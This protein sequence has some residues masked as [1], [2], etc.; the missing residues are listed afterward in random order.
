VVGEVPLA[1]SPSAEAVDPNTGLTYVALPGT[2]N[3][4]VLNGTNAFFVSIAVGQGPDGLAFDPADG[5]LFVANGL[6]D[7]LTVFNASTDGY[8]GTVA[9]GSDPGA[10]AVA[11]TLDQL[12]V[13]DAAGG[14]AGSLTIVGGDSLSVLAT[15]AVGEDPDAAAFDPDNGLVYVANEG[16]GN[17]SV[18]S[19]ASDTVTGSISLGAGSRP[20]AIAVDN[21][22][23]DLLVAVGGPDGTVDVVAPPSSSILASLRVGADPD[24][25][26]YDPLNGYAYVSNGGSGNLSVLDVAERQ[27]A[28]TIPA[29][30]APG[31]IVLDNETANLS[32]A[33]VGSA[34][35]EIVNGTYWLGGSENLSAPTAGS[36]RVSG[37]TGSVDFTVI[38]GNYTF[39]V[40]PPA[41]FDVAPAFA[42]LAVTGTGAVVGVAF[43]PIPYSLLTFYDEGSV[44]YGTSW[45]VVLDGVA[46]ATTSD[47][48]S[49]EEP[50]GTYTYLLLG[51]V[52]KRVDGIPATGS[53]VLNGTGGSGPT[54]AFAFVRGPTYRITFHEVGLPK[55]HAWCVTIGAP[56]CSTRP[57][58]D[59]VGLSPGTYPYVVAS[60]AG[61]NITATSGGV[62]IALAGAFTISD[63]S[64]S[65]ALKYV[66]PYEVTFTESGLPSGAVWSVRIAGELQSTNL[67]TLTFEI[68]NGTHGY[69]VGAIPGYTH[70]GVPRTVKV[71][72]AADEVTIT[73]AP[74]RP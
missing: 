43:T 70:V 74:T 25:L 63:R 29:G 21:A 54:E 65:V 2:D 1:S 37:G 4:T 55:G 71:E 48:E 40:L 20:T 26:C 27:V 22:T 33:N 10:L 39:R 49:F 36:D 62:G 41:G 45:T 61:D 52:G 31:A 16:S 15:L 17:L 47:A 58:L 5:Y 28:G 64:V 12:F 59:L 44:P 53:V 23:G 19:P 66:R 11:P 18:V 24:G 67:T 13:A 56:I 35:V 30:A 73:F 42:D 32:V 60:L 3:L 51:P 7:N 72:G 34:D 68:V 46:Y 14:G 50:A 9:T 38:D 8:V 69:R 6:S 57:T